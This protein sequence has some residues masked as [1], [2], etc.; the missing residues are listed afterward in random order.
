MKIKER[1]LS[2]EPHFDSTTPCLKVAFA[3]LDRQSV[4][5]HFGTAK[6]MMIFAISVSERHV[7]RAVEYNDAANATHDKLPVRIEDLQ[8][9]DA[10]YCNACGA[11]AIRQLLEKSVQP[12][13]VASKTPI[14]TLIEEVQDMLA[15]PTTGWVAKAL[16]RFGALEPNSQQHSTSRLEQ[17][18][19]EDW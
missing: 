9:C 4:D 14:S 15:H 12:I 19:E 17:L 10:V 3:T 2:L 18:M 8:D 11:S 16:Q 6:C 1:K 5:Q 13:K 7:V